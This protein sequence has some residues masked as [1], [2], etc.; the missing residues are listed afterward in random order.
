MFQPSLAWKPRLW[1]GFRWLRL[2][3]STG[4][5]KA[6]NDGWLWLGSGLSHSPWG[7]IQY[8][9]NILSTERRTVLQRELSAHEWGCLDFIILWPFLCILWSGDCI[10]DHENHSE[11]TGTLLTMLND[12]QQMKMNI[13]QRDIPC[14]HIKYT[15]WADVDIVV[16]CSC[17][18]TWPTSISNRQAYSWFQHNVLS[19]L[20]WM[21]CHHPASEITSMILIDHVAENYTKIT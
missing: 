1:P 10:S 8:K 3:K 16:T 17:V 4:W 19:F 14:F 2:S 7:K 6:V 20:C 18:C 9:S 5:A 21:S 13:N 11:G 15:L 12:C